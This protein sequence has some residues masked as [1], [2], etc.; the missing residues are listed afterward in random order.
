MTINPL[1]RASV[2]SAILSLSATWGSAAFAQT[3]SAYNAQ[4]D[5]Q[6]Q[7]GARTALPSLTSERIAQDVK[8]I[9]D[10]RS[11]TQEYVAPTFDPFENLSDIAGTASL[12]T[13]TQSVSI[14]GQNLQ[15]GAILDLAFFYNQIGGSPHAGGG[16]EKV[17]FQSGSYAPVVFKDYRALECAADVRH[18][19]FDQGF[20]L[21]SGFYHPYGHYFGH[22]RFGPIG[23][24]KRGISKNLFSGRNFF[25][26]SVLGGSAFG[27]NSFGGRNFGRN[28]L[29]QNGFARNNL[30]NRFTNNRNARPVTRQPITSGNISGL[31]GPRSRL[32]RNFDNQQTRPTSNIT[33]RNAT[34]RNDARRRDARIEARAVRPQSERANI[35][36]PQRERINTRRLQSERTNTPPRRVRNQN[37]NQDRSQ[38]QNQS[39]KISSRMILDMVRPISAAVKLSPQCK[40]IASA[41]ICSACISQG[42]YWKPRLVM[43]LQS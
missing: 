14:D 38:S 1:I 29:R 10:N 28:S 35:Q 17:L 37:R 26:R 23:F 9:F 20:H 36:R 4:Y 19:S 16:F 22:S 41:K 11:G 39:Q 25:G 5:S 31:G 40:Q 18:T 42:I 34:R 6:I 32:T 13:I 24:S 12:R 3:S 8:I 7:N 43:A 30:N 2:A 15:N 27:F 21:N 33:R